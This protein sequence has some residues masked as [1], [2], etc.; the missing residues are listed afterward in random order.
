MVS[1]TI[2]TDKI[3]VL[4]PRDNENQCQLK[5]QMKLLVKRSNYDKKDRDRK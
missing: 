1:N 4:K 3:A 2:T 5:I